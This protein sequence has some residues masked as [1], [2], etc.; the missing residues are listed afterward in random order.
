MM[1]VTKFEVLRS[2]KKK[3]FWYTTIALP[4]II[5]VIYGISYASSNHASKSDQ[6]Q[7]T[8]YS[9]TAKLGIFDETGLIN[10]QTLTGLHIVIE[11]SQQAGIASVEN[12]DLTA[13]F[14]YPKDVTKTGIEV[15]AQDTGISFT[16]PY[17]TLATQLLKNKA[18]LLQL[19]PWLI[20]LKPFRFC[21]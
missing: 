12:G 16:P 19:A 14:Y 21:K 6:Q 18:Q 20:T 1:S 11:P 7:T 4:L 10:K 13:F 8:S 9:K 15:Y 3:S 5:I 2:L 17:N